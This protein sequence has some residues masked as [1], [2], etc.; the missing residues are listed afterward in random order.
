MTGLSLPA[1]ISSLSVA[2][3]SALN[4]FHQSIRPV[5]LRLASEISGP[6]TSAPKIVNDVPPSVT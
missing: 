1:A 5:H 4:G 6:N 2:T 3:S